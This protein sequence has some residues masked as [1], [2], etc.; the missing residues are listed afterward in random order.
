VRYGWRD[1]Y[2]HPCETAVLQARI[3]RERGWAGAP[4]PCSAACLV[5]RA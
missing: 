2:G 3:L 5:G 1:V 4:R